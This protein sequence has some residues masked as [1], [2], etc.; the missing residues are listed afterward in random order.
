[1]EDLATAYYPMLLSWAK[2]KAGN[3]VN[4]ED[5][6]QEAML[7]ILIAARNT[8]DIRDMRRFVWKIAHYAYCNWLRAKSKARYVEISPNIPQDG[9]FAQEYADQQAHDERMAQLRRRLA[10][11]NR[12]QREAMILH[13]LDGLPVAKVAERLNA[14][15]AAVSWQ[16]FDARRRVK[17]DLTHM[18]H[19]LP[20]AYRPGRLAIGLSGIP[21]NDP[22]TKR[23]R[24]SLI[25]QN[26]C[27]LCY[28]EPKTMEALA[29]ATGIP[30]SYLE[31]DV[32]WLVEREFIAKTGRK[33]Q[34]AFPII[35]KR[36]YQNIGAMYM[37]SRAELIDPILDHLNASERVIRELGF[38]GAGEA[39]ERLLWPL[40]M[41][42]TSYVSRN[43]PELT[44]RKRRDSREIRPDG[45]RYYI[46]ASDLS[47]NQELDPNGYKAPP[48]WS[49]YYGICSDSCL[50]GA[51]EDHYY[52]LG[53]YN[54][55]TEDALPRIIEVRAG[56]QTALYELYIKLLEPDFDANSLGEYEKGA[57]A[58]EIASGI[59]S[60]EFKPR[61][62]AFT[63]AQFEC[64][65]QAVFA[66]LL[67]RLEPVFA[68][69]APR[70]EAMH[71]ASM[72][73]VNHGYIDYYTYVDLWDFGIHTFMRAAE[74]GMLKLPETPREGAP[75]TL[76]IIR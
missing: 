13:Y 67:T 55:T 10:D 42:F 44:K 35:S 19:A 33:Y 72:P 7:Q 40:I 63:R 27:L 31:Y 4:G 74:A 18:E 53:L 17:E 64:L 49:G 73:K 39:W 57:L 32:D 61:F 24:D 5:L 52:W 45:G 22:D 60:E 48:G 15:E 59:V 62:T 23:V 25:R 65:K 47:D 14:S 28:R 37:D 51:S 56:A 26:I 11:L 12:T 6:A 71:L 46:M 69:L 38:Y 30:L 58:D 3:T 54:F 16:L 41:L 1:M 36:H 21:G 70:I 8:E 2:R 34:T 76:V 50:P 29:E 43:C 9:D 75:L 66:P 20:T 68:A